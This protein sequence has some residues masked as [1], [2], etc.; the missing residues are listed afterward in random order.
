V[1]APRVRATSF[2]HCNLNCA[3][4]ARSARFYEQLFDLR[5]VM[6]MDD[7]EQDGDGIGIA[8]KTVSSTVFLYDHRGGRVG[9]ALELIGWSTPPLVGESYREPRHVGLQ[10]VAFGVP[11]LPEEAA[12]RALGGTAVDRGKDADGRALLAARDPDGVWVEMVEDGS[13]R[14]QARSLRLSCSDLE[15]SVAWYETIGFR[16]AR[17]AR[18]ESWPASRSGIPA[19][20]DVRTA[21]LTLNG[22][23]ALELVEWRRPRGDGRPYDRANHR[24]LYRMALAVD[25]VRASVQALAATGA[26]RPAAPVHFP[27]PGTPIAGLWIS[28]LRDPDGVVVELVER[29][30]AAG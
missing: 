20:A 8:G 9:P 14:A 16:V 29:P 27:L 1:A 21:S 5:A 7:A 15:R 12:V 2:L 10:G 11:R 18:D 22:A 3:D 13:A 26:H 6:R 17:A 28:F 30:G 25:D 24:G 19:G 23:Y 4:L